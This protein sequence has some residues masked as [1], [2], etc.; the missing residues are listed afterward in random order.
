MPD[1]Q[2]WKRLGNGVEVQRARIAG[3]MSYRALLAGTCVGR[4]RAEPGGRGCGGR[5]KVRASIAGTRYS[6]EWSTRWSLTLVTEWVTV[7]QELPALLLL[8]RRPPEPRLV[9]SPK[10]A[11]TTERYRDRV[12]YYARLDQMLERGRRL[13]AERAHRSGGGRPAAGREHPLREGKSVVAA[14]SGSVHDRSGTTRSVPSRDN[15]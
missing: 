4:F 8:L 3:R 1:W 7:I 2:T 15:A 6:G 10:A 12:A 14:Y 5:P 11:P 9:L 13:E